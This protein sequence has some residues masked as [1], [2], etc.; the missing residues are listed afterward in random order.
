MIEELEILAASLKGKTIQ[1]ISASFIGGAAD[2]LSRMMPLMGQLGVDVWWDVIKRNDS[3]CQVARKINN[4]LHGRK[5]NITPVNFEL[6]Q[7]ITRENVEEMDMYGDILF[8]HGLQPVGLIQKKHKLNKKWIWGCHIDISQPIEEAWNIL[9]PYIVQYDAAVFPAPAFSCKLPIKQFQIPPS[10]DPLSDR[11]K[12]LPDEVI[13][14]VLEK[15]GIPRDKPVITQVSYFDY[16]RNPLGVIEAF[17]LVRKNFNCRLVFVGGAAGDDPG[18]GKVLAEVRER[19]GNNPDIHVVL[20]PPNSDIE[21]NALQWGSTIILQ[22]SLGSGFGMTVSEALWKAKPVV[23]SPVGGIPLQVKNRLTGF[24]AHGVEDTALA[25]NQL[26]SNPDYAKRLGNNGR[27]H[28]KYNFLIT[29]HLRDY[30]TLF[31]T[32]DHNDTLINMMNVDVKHS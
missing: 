2:T 3:F 15:Y 9:K 18:S 31:L 6:F 26:L 8:I 27:E 11:N 23:A 5:E 28:V 24:L 22:K 7:E 13:A 1:N 30:L 14:D 20:V 19:A 12:E 17:E 10:I 21:I 16:L 29:R 4:A 32:L 25:I